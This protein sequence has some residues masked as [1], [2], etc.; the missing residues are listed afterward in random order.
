MAITLKAIDAKI[1]TFSTNKVA[2]QKLGHEIAMMIVRHAAPASLPDC[3]GSADVTRALKL[4]KQM[5]KSWQPQLIEWF[6]TYTPVIVVVKN[7]KCGLDPAYKELDKKDKPAAWKLEEAENNPFYELDEPEVTGKVLTID[8]LIALFTKVPDL[9]DKKIKEGLVKAED[10]EKAKTLETFA[11][12][13][14]FDAV[15]RMTSATP[16]DNSNDTEGSEENEAGA[17]SL[18][19]TLGVELKVA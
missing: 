15:K 2:L 18:S 7:D 11:R 13:I 14:N 1:T 4:A 10:V 12:G 16:N 3:D 19:E 8:Q 5:P 9:I 17:Q 6:K